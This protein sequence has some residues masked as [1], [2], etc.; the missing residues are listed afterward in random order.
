MPNETEE[1]VALTETL[2][3]EIE[4]DVVGF[5]ILCPYPGSELYDPNK[6]ADID[7]E[8]TDEYANDFWH[9]EHF[10]NAKLKELQAHLTTKYNNLLCERQQ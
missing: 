1:D 6:H 7:W 2:I 3:D 10:S 9:T 8:K 5:T 4:P